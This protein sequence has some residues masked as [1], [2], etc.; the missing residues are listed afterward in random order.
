[1]SLRFLSVLAAIFLSILACSA[2]NIADDEEDAAGRFVVEI[3]EMR[4]IASIRVY[5]GNVL[6]LVFADGG[7]ENAFPMTDAVLEEATLVVDTADAGR[8][9]LDLEK[10]SAISIR[11]TSLALYH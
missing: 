2:C 8:F 5:D 1:M 4:A 7:G 10:V 6:Q 3:S 11:E 9:Y